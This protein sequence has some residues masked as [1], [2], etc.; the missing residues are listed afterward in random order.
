M[1]QG[2][3]KDAIVHFR[4]ALQIDPNFEKARTNL[5]KAMAALRN[6]EP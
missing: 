2:Q 5:N 6:S 3:I 4:K 1:A